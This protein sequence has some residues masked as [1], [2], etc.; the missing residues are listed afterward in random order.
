VRTAV[1]NVRFQLPDA[2]ARA[3][4]NLELPEKLIAAIRPSPTVPYLICRRSSAASKF[5]AS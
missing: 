5:L 4:C 1:A 3:L 2:L